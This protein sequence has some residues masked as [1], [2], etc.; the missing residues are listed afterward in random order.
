MRYTLVSMNVTI[1]FNFGYSGEFKK[2]FPWK[3]CLSSD[4]P[5]YFKMFVLQTSIP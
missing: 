2:I 5:I 3:N 4:W 1:F